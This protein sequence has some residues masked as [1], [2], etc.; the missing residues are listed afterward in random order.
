MSKVESALKSARDTKV[1]V[2]GSEVLSQ[3]ADVFKKCFPGKGAVIVADKTTYRVA[4]ARV[5]AYLRG[6]GVRLEDSVVF[7][8]DDLYAEYGFVDVLAESLKGHCAIPVAVGSGT[9]NDLTKLA[10]SLTGRRYMCVAT[11]ASMDGYTAFGASITADGAK[12]TFDCPAPLACLADI[13]IISRAPSEMTAS[14]YADLYA[15][16]VAGADWIMADELGVEPIH[17]EAW[18]IVQDGLQGA[19]SDP[20]GVRRGDT[21]AISDLIQGLFLGGFAMQ[22][23]MSSRPASGAEHMFSHLWNMDHHLNNGN[24]VSHGFQVGIGTLAVTALYEQM[25]ATDIEHLDVEA[26]CKAWVSRA[27]LES[28]ATELFRNTDFPDIGTRESLAK[29][30]DADTLSGRLRYLKNNWTAIRSRVSRQLVSFS[31]TKRCLELVG[32]PVDP[33]QIGVS[34][35]Y[36]RESFYRAFYIRRRITI[37]DV[38]HMTGCFDR[39]IEGLF[40]K[41]GVWEIPTC[42]SAAPASKPTQGHAA[43]HV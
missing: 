41:G 4:G 1:L 39:W 32:A 31:E 40:G 14:G 26:A 3:V 37:L 16:I 2:V 36:L 11:A 24:H 17:E 27:E 8:D 35:E 28:M 20:Q 34:R 42:N 18:S 43:A 29:Y 21:K 10:S 6:A 15:K 30:I 7:T 33:E 5:E 13:D 12:Q 22:C 25:L 23:S 9:I 19:L 38:A